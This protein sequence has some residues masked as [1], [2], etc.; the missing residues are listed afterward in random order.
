MGRGRRQRARTRTPSKLSLVGIANPRHGR[1]GHRGVRFKPFGP[2]VIRCWKDSGAGGS[3]A[4][5]GAGQ[6]GDFGTSLAF[7]GSE[8]SAKSHDTGGG[9][10]LIA[11]PP[12]PGPPYLL[13]LLLGMLACGLLVAAAAGRRL[14]AHVR[15]TFD[16]RGG[17]QLSAVAATVGLILAVAVAFMLQA[18]LP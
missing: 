9:S 17:A 1:C 14:P 7:P 3:A 16:A 11:L 12:V 13:L 8:R 6:V 10:G 5:A 15:A 2:T 18:F 4:A